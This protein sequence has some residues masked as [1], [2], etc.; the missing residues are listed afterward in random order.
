MQKKQ[1]LC[2]MFW[3]CCIWGCVAVCL[4]TGCSRRALHEAQAVVKAAD[5]ARAEGRMYGTET[6]DSIALAQAYH[7]LN[8][9]PLFPYT[10]HH[11]PYTIHLTP[12]TV[13]LTPYTFPFSS[14]LLFVCF[15]VRRF[16]LVSVQAWRIE[17]R[18][19]FP[20]VHCTLYLVHKNFYEKNLYNICSK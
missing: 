8:N 16:S 17:K 5:S 2:T 4:F 19:P 3:K 13:H 20:L 1:Y 11:T 18:R 6:E 9:H 15:I 12:Y 14:F 7:T 10:V